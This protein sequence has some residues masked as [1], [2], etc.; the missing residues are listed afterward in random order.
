MKCWDFRMERSDF[1]MKYGDFGMVQFFEMRFQDG[2]KL[3]LVTSSSHTPQTFLSQPPDAF[4]AAMV[5]H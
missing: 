4:G 1:G 2:A 3:G 5:V